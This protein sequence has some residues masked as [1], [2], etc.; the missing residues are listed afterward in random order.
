[1]QL[2]FGSPQYLAIGS[3]VLLVW[4]LVEIFGSPFFRNIEVSTNAFASHP[5]DCRLFAL[6]STAGRADQDA[7]DCLGSRSH[8]LH[9]LAS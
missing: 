9:M 2:P 8:T 3:L 7:F 1:M 5:L 4:V 6:C